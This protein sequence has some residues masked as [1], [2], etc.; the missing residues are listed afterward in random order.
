[1]DNALPHKKKPVYPGGRPALVL[2]GPQERSGDLDASFLV[3][4]SP[5][6]FV[7][8]LSVHG[9]FGGCLD[10]EAH[11]VSADLD[12]HDGDLVP[13]DDLLV[14]LAAKN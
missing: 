2:G 5:D 9:D 8:L 7:H 14:L 12:H 13:D 4:L 6:R 1:M 3:T 11:F 10:A